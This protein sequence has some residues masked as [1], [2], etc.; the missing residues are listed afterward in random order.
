MKPIHLLFV[1][2]IGL[3]SPAITQSMS[4]H[5]GM[6]HG[7]SDHT[8]MVQGS[9]SA[10]NAPTQ[11]G[12]AAFAAIQEI[13]MILMS[14]PATNW[15]R[16]DV[17]ALRQH[18]V[19]MNNVTMRADVEA[20]AIDGG[21]RFVVSSPDAD[22]VA[23]IRRMSF[24]HAATMNGTEGWDFTVKETDRGVAFTATGDAPR[25]RSLGFVGLMTVGAHHQ[26]HH[27]ALARGDMPH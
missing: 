14:D 20:E 17:S 26:Q 21:A 19:D 4:A 15:D 24:A 25:I 2:A 8:M 22:V 7:S 12:Q 1:A 10:G 9:S 3:P 6:N 23:S 18:L 11:G 27:L 13:V 5:D 16:V